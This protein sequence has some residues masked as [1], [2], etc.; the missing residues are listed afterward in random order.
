MTTLLETVRAAHL[1]VDISPIERAYAVAARAHDGQLRK[2]GDPYI[3]HPVTVATIVAEIGMSPEIIC[4]AL[5]HDTVEDTDY[6]LVRLREDFGEVVADLVDGVTKLDQIK[7]GAVV[8]DA[9]AMRQVVLEMARDPR[10][11]VLKLA[12]RLHNM[13]TMRFLP[14]KEQ[15]RKARETLEVFAP[16]AHQLG[17]ATI[18]RELDDLATGI[19]YPGLY[20]QRRRT[21]AEQAL[22]ASVLL[23]PAAQ[24]ARWFEEWTGEL[25]VL[26]SRRA[27]AR[28]AVQMLRGMPRLAVALRRPATHRTHRL[29]STIVDE[30]VGALGIG[31]ALLTVVARW[32]LAAWTIGAMVFGGLVLLGAV[33]FAHS[34]APANRLRGLVRAWRGPVT[35]ARSSRRRRNRSGPL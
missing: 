9:E 28:F 24:R 2:S 27:R 4:A 20:D 15:A 22:A 11:V 14:P 25:S 3:T 7:L 19:L 16:L 31:A 5:L 18:R 30:I 29:V 17:I 32:E 33:L 8:G 12:D 21:V 35:T 6:S 26:P 34:D 1:G 23:L 13:R 10:V